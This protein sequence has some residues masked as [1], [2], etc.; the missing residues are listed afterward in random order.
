[1]LTFYESIKFK[2]AIFVFMSIKNHIK[3]FSPSII[4][5]NFFFLSLLFLCIA[6]VRATDAILWKSLETRHT[7][8]HY[9]SMSDLKRFN[10]KVDYSPGEWG[11]K[12]LFSSSNANMAMNGIKKKVDAVYERVQQ[13][14]D[15]RKRM[16]KVTINIYHNKNQLRTAYYN[17]FKRNRRIRAWYLYEHNTIYIN[18]DDLHEGILAHEMAHSIIDNYLS[19][20]PP[21]A[22]AEILARYVDK[23]LFK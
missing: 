17:I 4:C 6:E 8:I 19:V 13:I 21:P 23:H 15:M 18:V 2:S 11:L 16:K 9:Q 1:M 3:V 20:R 5:C 7:I 12:G 14:L 22:S 10:D